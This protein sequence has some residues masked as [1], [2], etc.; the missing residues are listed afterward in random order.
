MSEN[1]YGGD[2]WAGTE[3][4]ETTGFPIG[5]IQDDV[6]LDKVE[7][8]K[9][10]SKK[11]TQ[12]EAI[13]FTF[14]KSVGST[15]MFLTDQVL[16]LNPAAIAKWN[17][18]ISEA[19]TLKKEKIRYFSRL[20]HI[21]TKLGCSEEEVQNRINNVTSF[22]DLAYKV[23]ALTDEHNKG[24][25]MYM[26][27]SVSDSGYAQLSKYPGFLQAMSTGDCILKFSK[28]ELKSI[29]KYKANP[30]NGEKI[31]EEVHDFEV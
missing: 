7:Y 16:P 19:E 12:Y 28:E 20:K 6:V 4:G 10:D 5:T 9:G 30:S 24:Q 31:V 21:L 26:K 29:E 8:F 14:K 11:G 22:A 25:K 18:E 2:L 15:T 17:H 1:I 13:K 3:A 23:K 27:I